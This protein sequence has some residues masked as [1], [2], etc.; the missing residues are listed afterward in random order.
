VRPYVDG[1]PGD[2]AAVWSLARR[3]CAQWSLPAPELLR[4]GMNGIF[5]A[6]K[7][8][9]RVGRVTGSPAAAISLADVVRD[10]GVRVPAPARPDAIDDGGLTATAWERLTPS[11]VPRSLKLSASMSTSGP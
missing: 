11:I 8:V 3:A 9:V 1:P 6:G 7:V 10:A 4:I 5:V 2:P